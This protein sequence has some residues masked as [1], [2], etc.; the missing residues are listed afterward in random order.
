MYGFRP[1]FFFSPIKAFSGSLESPGQG[2]S[3]T[4]LESVFDPQTNTGRQRFFLIRETLCAHTLCAAPDFARRLPALEAMAT[5]QGG[6]GEFRIKVPDFFFRAFFSQLFF[7]R[8]C[9]W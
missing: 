6:H 9:F 2:L 4:G 5:W 7:P 3:K 8:L 1:R